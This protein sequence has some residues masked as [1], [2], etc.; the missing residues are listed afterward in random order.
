MLEETEC[1][2]NEGEKQRD[3]AMGARTEGTKNVAAIELARRQEIER[4]REEPDPGGAADGMEKE[5]AGVD[6]GMNDGCEEAQDER[7]AEDDLGVSGIRE[8]GNN[9]GMEDS[10]NE[11]RNGENEADKRAR[12]ADIEEGAC[13]TDRGSDENECAKSADERRSGDEEGVAGA[14]MVMA[15]G[16]E[17]TKF[18][19]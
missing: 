15:A 17:M 7:N 5:T 2:K 4:S 6:T 3:R 1:D 9:L 12:R 11:C 18:M 13:G 16:E 10:I 8:S 19:R 14:N